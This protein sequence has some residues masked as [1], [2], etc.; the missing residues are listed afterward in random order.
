M[1]PLSQ[2]AAWSVRR[3][4]WGESI[5]ASESEAGELAVREKREN[6]ANCSWFNH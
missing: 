4:E 5:V 1:I 6:E 3:G 2:R